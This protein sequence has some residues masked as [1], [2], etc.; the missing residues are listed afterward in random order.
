MNAV[1]T[2][3]LVNMP[4]MLS[5][6]SRKASF[7][8]EYARSLVRVVASVFDSCHKNQMALLHARGT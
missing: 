7:V 5:S 2:K 3:F 1:H 8:P 4:M 6:R